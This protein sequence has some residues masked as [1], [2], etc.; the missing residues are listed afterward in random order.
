MFLPEKKKI[1]KQ[2]KKPT[3]TKNKKQKQKPPTYQK[4]SF[5]LSRMYNA[6][7]N[8]LLCWILMEG[9]V[10]VPILPFFNRDH[11][12]AGAQGLQKAPKMQENEPPLPAREL[13]ISH[14]VPASRHRPLASFK[15]KVGD[16]CLGRRW[17]NRQPIS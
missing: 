9:E 4:G 13:L 14:P 10:R 2:T 15:L 3:K 7:E 17:G 1:K 16:G 11:G 8:F 6:S 5:T 12:D